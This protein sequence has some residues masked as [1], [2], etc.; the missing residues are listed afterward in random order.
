MSPLSPK[1]FNRWFGLSL[2]LLCSSTSI[3]AL[4]IPDVP[5][6]LTSTGVKPNL[7][8][9]L[10]DSASMISAYLPDTFRWT[11]DYWRCYPDCADATN[12]PIRYGKTNRFKSADFNLMYYDPFVTYEIPV[13]PDGVTYTTS[14]NAAKRNGY[15][16]SSDT[17]D[18]RSE[19]KVQ[20]EYSDSPRRSLDD[21]TGR[22]TYA[23]YYLFYTKAGQSKPSRCTTDISRQ[24]DDDDCYVEIKVTSTSGPGGTDER[25]NFANWYSFYRT[26]ALATVSGAMKAMANV[27]LDSLRLGWQNLNCSDTN[28]NCCNSLPLTGYKCK[29]RDGNRTN[30]DN[31][32]RSYD[33]D[34]RTDFLNWLENSSPPE[35]S[36]DT[37]TPLQAAMERAG[38][39]YSTQGVHSPYAEDPQNDLGTVYSCRRNFH[40]MMTDGIWNGGTAWVGNQ[41]GS[42][43]LAM[44]DGRFTYSARHPYSD[45]QRN[46]L[47]DLAFK[48]WA[49]DL[50]KGGDDNA[51]DCTGET[52]NKV[53]SNIVDQAGSDDAKYWNPKNDPATWQHMS[54]FMLSLGLGGS[55]T[56]PAWGG[57]TYEG[58][59]TL[60]ASGAKSWPSINVNDDDPNKVYD[61]W[62]SAI[63]SRGL[64]L[65]ADDPQSLSDAF[66]ELIDSISSIATSGGGAGLGSNSTNI[67]Q[68]GT[69]IFEAKFNADW[70]G[71]LLARPVEADYELGN[72]YWDA[73]QL[74]PAPYA[75]NIFTIDDSGSA[76]AFVP[77]NCSGN[78]KTELDKNATG[79]TDANLSCEQRVNW[80]LG[81]GR[82]EDAQC[83]DSSSP[84][85]LRL[86]LTDHGFVAGDAITITGIKTTSGSSANYNGSFQ[87]DAATTN[88]FDV[89][90]SAGCE[91]PSYDSGGRVR[92][93]KFRNR[94]NSVL[95]DIMNSDPV[96]VSDDDDGYGDS[97]STIDG[98]SSYAT[99]VSSKSSAN[100]PPMLYAGANDGMLHGFQADIKKTNSG[101]ELLGYV[102]R[103]VYADLSQLPNPVYSHKYYV[104]GPLSV[105]DAYFGTSWGTY[106]VGGLGSGGKSIFALDISDPTHFD[107][108]DVMWEFNDPDDTDEL[109]LTYSRPQIAPTTNSQ[110]GVIFGNGYNSKSDKAYFYVVNLEN[111]TQVAKIATNNATDN[112]LSTPYLYDMDGNKIVDVVYAGDLK[113]NLWKFIN[114]SGSWSLGN[115]GN[116]LFTANAGQS[117]TSQPKVAAH[118][119]GGVLVYFGTGS[120]LT[121]K[122]LTDDNLQTFYAIWDDGKINPTRTRANLHAYKIDP[123]KTVTFDTETYTARTTSDQT[124][125]SSLNWVTDKGWYLDLTRTAGIASERIISTPLVMEF[126]N[127]SVPD[128][129]LFVTNT[130]ASDRCDRGGTTWLMELDLITGSHT[131]TS[132][133]DLNGDGV[134]DE[135]DMLDTDGDG[136]GDTAISGLA[137]PKSYGLT[138]EPLLLETDDG[139][140]VKEFS[141]STGESGPAGGPMQQGEP[142]SSGTAI[143]IYW[144]QI[145]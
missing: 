129:I 65:S 99:Y 117:I 85:R 75:R 21:T 114:Q 105:S 137:L 94:A 3:A 30:R 39:Y 97:T 119:N 52:C 42:S 98:H 82:V 22:A 87:V 108:T 124:S 126:I 79:G 66:S 107:A 120:Y 104:D 91:A 133:Y 93:T 96:F 6:F 86:T 13:R 111:G 136:I 1:T 59:Y 56:D 48:Y 131:A 92:Y 44:P 54:N 125:G 35:P 70:S 24:K 4:D 88:S 50:R 36:S 77:A 33:S 101:V 9:T 10:D 100:R 8:I 109:G 69:V 58:D 38:D 122:D 113:G 49:T 142:H 76:V 132:V 83:D 41:D 90:L 61:L 60:L 89:S 134:F 5:L 95:G 67:D 32:I 14:F 110:W 143:R 144:K 74:I 53:P 29:A 81:D 51:A 123:E 71:Q 26:R 43:R 12:W 73:G 130:P 102:P 2:G 78:L 28:Y 34:H 118:P 138:A 112:G 31:R 15:N 145:Q 103:G 16:R 17:V 7:V 68:E 27:E 25:A 37:G 63:N 40:L 62:H 84:A 121:T 57:S 127:P 20:L 128:R 11:G 45:S 139:K 19:Y 80:L 18:L 64:F 135:K 47:A 55:L 116:P 106:L 140:I 46:T 72:E 115:G 23:Y 141:G